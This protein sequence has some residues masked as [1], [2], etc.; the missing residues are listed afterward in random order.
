MTLIELQTDFSVLQYSVADSKHESE[1]VSRHI[2]LL[3]L[4]IFSASRLLRYYE[5]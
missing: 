5:T 4:T 3:A 1:K 2:P